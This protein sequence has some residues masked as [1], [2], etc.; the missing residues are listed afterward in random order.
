MPN[1]A[2]CRKVHIK[3]WGC[4]M[5]AYDSRRMEDVLAPLGYTPTD[6]PDEAD[7]IILNTCHIR[8]KATE[9][10][11]SELGRMKAYK[12]RGETI[13]KKVLLGVA[14]CVAQAE[15]DIIMDRA[16]YVDLVFGPQ[17]YH[18]LAEM[19]ADLTGAR[20]NRVVNTDFPTISKFDFLP[21][22]SGEIG[23]A[24]YLSVQEGCDKFCTF[25]VVPYTRGAEYSRAPIQI[26]EEA[27]R[28]TD[29]GA[30]EIMLLGQNVNAYHGEGYSLAKLME[31]LLAQVP[32]VKRLRYTT[33]HP[34]D[35]SQD[36][37]DA[38]R[39]LPGLMPYLHLPVQSGADHVLKIMNRKHNRDFY[40]EILQ[41]LRAAR[42]DI[43]LSGDFIVGFPGE[44]GQDF[45]DT[46]SIVREARYA[47]AYCFKYSARP[48]TPAAIMKNLVPEPV[49]DERLARLQA[50]IN[51]Q[52]LIFNQ[53]TLGK[54]VPVLFERAGHKGGLTGRTPYNQLIAIGDAPQ[55]WLGQI[56]DVKITKAAPAA[57]NGEAVMA[58]AV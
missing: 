32:A 37:I 48:G 13:G 51:E 7:M 43:A 27:K 10:L 9:K 15:G 21:E 41:R 29:K 58:E 3:T 42:P 12:N 46:L 11:F 1:A 38:H 30:M 53:S 20:K 16:P 6:A 57:V 18:T 55:G 44:T 17:T 47:S 40:L 36:L 34:R 8:E 19:I 5:N 39:D 28:L 22:E 14:G 26:I 23:P 25:C 52:G 24:A 49:K 50:A 35:M 31:E 33:S 4:Q 45:E 56:R 54:T 2:A